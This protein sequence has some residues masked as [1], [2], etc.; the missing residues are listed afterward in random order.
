MVDIYKII[1]ER[2]SKQRKALRLSQESLANISGL[3]RNYIGHIERGE[4]HVT[5]KNLHKIAKALNIKLS[6]LFNDF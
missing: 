3:H 5:I 1:G 4:R 2:L 6:E